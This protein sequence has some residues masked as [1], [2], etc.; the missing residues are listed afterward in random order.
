VRHLPLFVLI[1]GVVAT[2]QPSFAAGLTN[3]FSRY[4]REPLNATDSQLL[5]GAVSKALDEK[6]A[7]ATATWSDAA[8]GR[9]GQATVLQVYQK[10]GA[11]C[12]KV[13]HTYTQGGGEG[14]VLPFCLQK[15]G[16]WKIQF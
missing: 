16:S 12:G 5:I 2:A 6:K 11:D 15:D 7:G 1:T 4:G 13:K 9:S 14:Y 8:T 10:N 3:P